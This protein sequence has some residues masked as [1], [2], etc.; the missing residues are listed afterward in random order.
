[1]ANKFG[2]EYPVRHK[3][4][5]DAELTFLSVA[6]TLTA[7]GWVGDGG[8]V[9]LDVGNAEFTGFL[10]LDLASAPAVDGGDEAYTVSFRG[11]KDSGF[12]SDV[13][14]LSSFE[15]GDAAVIYG[16]NDEVSTRYVVPVWNVLGENVYPYLSV[17]VDTVGVTVSLPLA[18]CFLAKGR[19]TG[20]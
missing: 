20:G 17:Y 16:D 13:V 1:M 2:T 12:A 8:Q 7:D 3:F 5:R 15:I 11:S 9:I 19:F 14:E 18:A 6:Q 10:V 4:I